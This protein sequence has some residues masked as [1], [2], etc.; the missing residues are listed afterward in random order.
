MI[1]HHT[2]NYFRTTKKL[3]STSLDR[4]EL[5]CCEVIDAPIV[6]LYWLSHQITPAGLLVNVLPSSSLVRGKWTIIYI[7]SFFVFF[8]PFKLI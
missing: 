7:A 4:F 8:F 5:S 1:Y 3:A 2:S 6:L